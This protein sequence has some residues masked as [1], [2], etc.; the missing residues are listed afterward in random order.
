[1]KAGNRAPTCGS[2]LCV[3]RKIRQ[4]I[5]ELERAG[6]RLVPGGKGAHRKFRHPR[7]QGSLILSGKT[8]DDAQHYQERAVRRAIDEA[9]I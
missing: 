9:T 5:A 2:F 7:L 3:P 6:F 4:L 1:M 8:G